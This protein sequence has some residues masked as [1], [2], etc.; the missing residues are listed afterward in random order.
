MDPVV[1]A[2]LP[3]VIF[4]LRHSAVGLYQLES[5]CCPEQKDTTGGALWIPN[6]LGRQGECCLSHTYLRIR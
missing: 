4:S 1:L 6:S 5:N 3:P 2:L